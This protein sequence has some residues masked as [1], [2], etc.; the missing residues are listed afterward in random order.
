MRERFLVKLESPA[1]GGALVDWA[2]AG[3]REHQSGGLIQ[4]SIVMLGAWLGFDLMRGRLSCLSFDP[5]FER[6][7]SPNA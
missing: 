1:L 4:H 6:K 3:G 7:T 5:F 2:L